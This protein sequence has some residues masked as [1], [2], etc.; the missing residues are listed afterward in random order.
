MV[1]TEGRALE[2]AIEAAVAPVVRA[3]GL[4][5]VDVDLRAGG[6]RAVLRLFVD[7]P[8][9]VGIDDCRRLS[10]EVGDVLDVAD[11]LATSYDLEVSS[12]GLDRE[13]RKDRELRWAL[14]KPVRAWT[15]EPVEGRLEFAGQLAEVD[16]A[17]LTVVE[18]AGP[19]RLPR[20][21]VTKVRLALTPGGAAGAGRSR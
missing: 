17:T 20:G 11:V 21:L 16:E 10:D 15:R 5:L 14:G 13:L 12:P 6:R 2:D 9:G 8:G 4:T 19:R 18:A 1:G 3:H 7:R